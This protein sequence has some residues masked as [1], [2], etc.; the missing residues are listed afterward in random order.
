MA[1]CKNVNKSTNSND[2]KIKCDNCSSN[3]I[4][5]HEQGYVCV[6]CGIVI[7]SKIF[8]YH[9]PYEDKRVQHAVLGGTTIGTRRERLRTVA[10]SRLDKLNKL[11]CIQDSKKLVNIKARSEIKR[12][13]EHLHLPKSQ[14]NLVLARF[15]KFRACLRPGTKYRSPEK[16]VPLTIY[17]CLKIRN[18]SI[19]EQELL[20][21]SKITKKEFN[22]FKLQISRFMPE[23][24]ERNRKE[25]VLQKIMELRE[26]FKL[27]M[28]FYYQSKTI[29]YRLWN[30]INCTKDDVIA[31]V[32][33]SMVLLCFYKEREDLTVNALCSKLGIRMSTIQ[34]QVKKRIFDRFKIPN[35]ESLVKSTDDLRK[36][37]LKLNN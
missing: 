19:N 8:E 11:H 28:E 18:M 13:F 26:H 7:E 20:E 9:K 2:L 5:D 24:A 29:M 33:S 35:F 1:T 15:K 27:N 23:Y 32:V 10:S 4:K 3:N 12:I 31:G 30:V 34:S 16:L 36:V 17:F 25:Y 21:V 14:S 6:D 22:A 37:L